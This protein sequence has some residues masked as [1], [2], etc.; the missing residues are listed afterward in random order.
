LKHLLNNND[1][2]DDDDDDDD[3]IIII[4]NILKGKKESTFYIKFWEATWYSTCV[5]PKERR[6]E[7]GHFLLQL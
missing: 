7:K 5:C 1:D 6:H 4:K 2:D 3:V